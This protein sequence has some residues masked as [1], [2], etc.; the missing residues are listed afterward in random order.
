MF[1]LFLLLRELIRHTF[2]H[3]ASTLSQV[4][5]IPAQTKILI[6]YKT[7]IMQ[8]MPYLNSVS[9]GKIYHYSNRVVPR[10]VRLTLTEKE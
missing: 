5:L 4:I 7:T 3:S 1:H 10:T 9:V 8:Q 6:Q 2:S